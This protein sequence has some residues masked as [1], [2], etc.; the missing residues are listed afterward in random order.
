MSEGIV[1]FV[2]LARYNGLNVGIK[3]SQEAIRA[4]NA[5]LLDS[6][7]HLQ[8]GLKALF[9]CEEEQRELFDQLFDQFWGYERAQAQ[10]KTTYKNESNIQKKGTASLVMMGSGE[11]EP[12]EEEEAKNV[13]GANAVE[14]LRKTDF[15]KLEEMDSRML[16]ELA[17]KLWQQMSKRI[18]RK[19]KKS[20]NKGRLDLRQTIHNSISHGGDPIELHRK[21]KAPR[22]QRLIVLLDVSGSMDKYS[23]F[24]LRFVWSL[25]AHFETVEA[26]I[27]STS[28]IRITDYLDAKDLEWTLQVLSIQAN[29]WSSGTEIGACLRTFNEKYAKQVLSGRSTTLVLSDGLETGEPEVLASE[30]GKIKRRTRRLIW[31]NPLKGMKGYE[32]IQRGMSAALP[33]LDVFQSAHNL[34]SLLELENYLGEV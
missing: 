5:G 31:L 26:F 30:L 12:G 24:L 16:E 28:L 8:Y 15:S 23:F 22:K 10:G 1:S 4:A 29:N 3:E 21:K 33:E 17:L 27:F 14:R 34:D 11:Q 32:P 9:C 7:L 25:R 18:K 2:R 19:M 13:S 20:V 6:K